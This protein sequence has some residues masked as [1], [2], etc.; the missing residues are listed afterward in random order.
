MTSDVTDLFG[1]YLRL[2]RELARRSDT[3]DAGASDVRQ[4]VERFDNDCRELTAQSQRQ[5]RRELSIQVEQEA[6]RHGN[7][8]QRAVFISVLKHLEAAE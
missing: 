8:K 6:L 3:D 5:L 4:L 1:R 2:T 7:A